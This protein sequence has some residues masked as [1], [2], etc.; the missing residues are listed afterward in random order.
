MA[1]LQ[2]GLE[3]PPGPEVRPGQRLADRA[4]LGLELAGALQRLD[5]RRGVPRRKEQPDPPGTAR[6]RRSSL[7]LHTRDLALS[8]ARIA[9]PSDPTLA[10]PNT[11]LP[12]FLPFRGLRYGDRRPRGRHRPT[13]RRH[14]RRRTGRPHRPIAPQRVPA[15]A[16][17]GR[18]RR[19]RP[20]A[21]DL[22]R[23]RHPGAR[24]GAGVLRLRDA[25]HRRPRP[26]PPHPGD[27]RRADAAAPGRRGRRA[28]PRAHDAEGQ[29]RPARAHPG[30]PGEP[31]PDLGP[32]PGDRPAGGRGRP[33]GGDH[34]RPRRAALA[35]ADHRRRDPAPRSSGSSGRL[36]W[37]SPTA[38]TASRPRSRTATS[39][40]RPA[41]R[42]RKTAG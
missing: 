36:R 26:A 21:R 10:E 40:P 11:P 24:S 19:R 13:L 30:H 14:R 33:G 18:L 41:S 3:E 12:E 17:R 2:L 20:R 31:R 25:V 5:R 34:R 35:A 29:E 15:A 27:H 39:G 38:T 42:P 22:V 7:A 8:R 23:R 32:D 1:E 28:S 6:T 16:P 9:G 4:L 37:S